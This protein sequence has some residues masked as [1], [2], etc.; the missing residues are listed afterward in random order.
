MPPK[1][2][3]KKV[4][5]AR[6]KDASKPVFKK[7]PTK[8]ELMP[9]V[10]EGTEKLE[11][12]LKE[13]FSCYDSD[14]DEQ[15]ERVEF[16]EGEELRIGKADFGP[17]ERKAAFQWFKDSGAEGT[18]TDGM[19]LSRANFNEGMK[20]LAAQESGLGVDKP[21][22]LAEWLWENR[23]TALI[24]G[25][26]RS[27]ATSKGVT[28][29]QVS[30]VKMTF[31]SLDTNTDG[32]LDFHEIHELFQKMNAGMSEDDLKKLFSKV[33]KS[34][35]GKVTFDEFIDFIFDGVKDTECSA[36]LGGGSTA[37]KYPKTIAFKDLKSSIDE[38][39]RLGRNILI[40]ACEMEQVERYMD[41]QMTIPLDCKQIINEVYFK[42]SKAKED[43]Q[44]E[45]K[46]KLIA[47]MN[48]SGFCKPLW[49]RLNNSAFDFVNF[50]SDSGFPADVFC[51]KE[52][53]T[54]QH[55][56]D[57]KLLDEKQKFELQVEDEKKWKD[58]HLIITSTYNLDKA[59]E[60]LLDKI[61]HY[62]D[63][64][65]LIIDPASIA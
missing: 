10:A 65:I 22:E 9:T 21:G 64:A 53:W 40:L 46:T 52:V 15:V 6:A 2:V 18:P 48:S 5:K 63:L 42:K 37:V 57:L 29:E 4:P 56:F 13:M 20:A 14:Q 3:A 45:A 36:G 58:F 7:E 12:L 51:S 11:N 28:P 26:Y 19:F 60:H 32:A 31:K 33:N 50:C 38:A 59:N 8:A 16:L 1:A 17:K 27:A 35:S 61:P 39:A 34:G 44:E 54:I 25:V 55:A 41:Y 43:W 47:A 49:V 24:A 62:D 23:A 30:K